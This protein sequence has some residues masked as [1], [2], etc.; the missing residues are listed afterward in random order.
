MPR[1]T[2]DDVFDDA[3]DYGLLNVS[4]PVARSGSDE[5]EKVACKLS[6][7]IGK[8]GRAPDD[9]GEAG[10]K[11]RLLAADVSRHAD[12]PSVASVL[13]TLAVPQSL[14]DILD[15]DLIDDGGS[16]FNMVHVSER[17]SAEQPD[18]IGSRK[19]CEDF[20]T[21]KPIFDLAVKEVESGARQ[22]LPFAKEQEIRPGQF[23]IVKGMLS[24]VASA[25]EPFKDRLGNTNRRLRV[26]YD[27]GTEADPL[28]RSFSSRLYGDENG[29]RLS[30]PSA[31]PLF[32]P[33]VVEGDRTGTIYLAR[34]LSE[35]PDVRRHAGRLLKLG[36]TTGKA[37]DRI[38]G[39]E[40]DPTFL[41]ARVALVATFAL[42]NVDPRALENVLH[43]FF[44][45]ARA[46][47]TISG[48]FGHQV[49]PREWFFIDAEAVRVAVKLISDGNLGEHQFN[50]RTGQIEKRTPTV[51]EDFSSA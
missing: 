28:L 1:R 14:D 4:A 35:H 20:E 19:P 37:S 6:A 2:L 21:F 8:H 27:N 38:K 18:Y 24:Y 43:K 22:A 45:S 30:D 13:S 49:R 46:D 10:L 44:E 48:L 26:I 50:L 51:A 9:M 47:A 16:I 17:A 39:A 36:V 12:A 25:G 29:R 7:F 3:D 15:S 33:T 32:D 5:A 23:F 31:G 34:S 11:E 42:E 40:K 41:H